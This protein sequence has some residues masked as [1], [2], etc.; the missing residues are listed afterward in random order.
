MRISLVEDDAFTA[1][2]LKKLLIAQQHQVDVAVTGLA[3]WQ[4]VESNAYDLLL[5]WMLPELDKISFCC[6]L[7]SQQDGSNQRTPILLMTAFD[8]QTHRITGLDAG[9]DDYV[10]KP[11][12]AEEL[13]ARI[14]ALLRRSESVL[15][16]IVER[17]DLQLD[18]RDCRVTH[19][20]QMLCP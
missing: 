19:R 1:A 5:D 11:F 17:G 13:L 3:G 16:S 20:G 4:L 10:V 8:Y 2:A 15:S 18:P 12:D 7:R 9:A 6:Q 14:R